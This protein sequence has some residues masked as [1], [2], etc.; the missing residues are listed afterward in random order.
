MSFDDKSKNDLP[1]HRRS[2]DDPNYHEP[3]RE[4]P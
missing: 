3:I 2:F 1:F 4:R